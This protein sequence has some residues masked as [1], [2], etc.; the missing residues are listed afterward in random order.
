[1]K[2]WQNIPGTILPEHTGCELPE[3]T[4]C[5]ALPAQEMS[6][7]KELLSRHGINP[8]K[9]LGQ[10]FVIDPNTIGRILAFGK[11]QKTDCVV[12]I[13][14]GCGALTAGL[15]GIAKK[16]IAIETDEQLLPILKEALNTASTANTGGVNIVHADAMSLD[17]QELL[18]NEPHKLVANL[19]YNIAA[20]LILKVLESYPQISELVVMVQKEVA[21]NF[22]AEPGD[23][24]FGRLALKAQFYA[25]IS[26]GGK[27]TP[28]VFYPKPK[29]D[30]ALLRFVRRGALA[31]DNPKP[32]FQLADA[33]FSKRR[34]M[35]RRSLADILN[36]QAFEKAGID[37]T[38]R[39]QELS[40]LEWDLLAR[41]DSR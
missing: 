15:A 37:P 23:S 18:G 26:S 16:V 10:N 1:M 3:H 35:I 33:A 40:F 27:V 21:E 20:R 30:S 17:F 5:E 25:E 36:Y 29:V 12:E 34:K 19:P 6:S 4:G 8:K 31:S 7:L 24:N 2:S 38:A 28:F 39:P 32:A 11:I 14:A 22:L 13:G 9:S 41:A